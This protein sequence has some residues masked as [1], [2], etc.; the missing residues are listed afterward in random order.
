MY[1]R[2]VPSSNSKLSSQPFSSRSM[3]TM[4]PWTTSTG[5]FS[6]IVA[7]S[8]LHVGSSPRVRTSTSSVKFSMII[9]T[10]AAAS[11]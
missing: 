1:P 5:W 4:S 3:P 2:T 10:W 9:A 11:P 6:S 8:S 7:V